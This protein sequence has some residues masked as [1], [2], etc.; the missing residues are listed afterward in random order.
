MHFVL[1][2]I[3]DSLEGTLR[4]LT[5]KCSYLSLSCSFSSESNSTLPFEYENMTCPDIR[6][7][8]N[9][10]CCWVSFA[11]LLLALGVSTTKISH[12]KFQ[13]ILETCGQSFIRKSLVKILYKVLFE[14]LCLGITELHKCKERRCS[15]C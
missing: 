9:V 14:G 10:S 15:S 2:R 6:Y 8:F 12:V 4:N 11:S 13:Q 1:L 3:L 7:A 5:L